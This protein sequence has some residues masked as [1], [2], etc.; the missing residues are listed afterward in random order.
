MSSHWIFAGMILDKGTIACFAFGQLGQA[1]GQPLK[2]PS[3]PSLSPEINF[4]TILAFLFRTRL[5]T[6]APLTRQRKRPA[7]LSQP[8]MQSSS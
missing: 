2:E 5:S 3:K 7:D 6:R 1:S 4:A 8:K